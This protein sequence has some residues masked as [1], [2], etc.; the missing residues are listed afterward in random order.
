MEKTKIQVKNDTFAQ[1]IKFC[2]VGVS[3]TLVDWASFYFLTLVITPKNLEPIAKGIA[4]L[5]AM[6]N[7]YFWN[8]KWTFKKEYENQV[9]ESDNSTKAK[10]EIFLKFFL[11]SLGGWLINVGSFWLVRFQFNQGKIVALIAASASA[12][13]FNFVI[14]KLWTYREEA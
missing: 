7:S 14:N 2:V 13:M 8:S 1:F 11:V 5:I 9:N 4:F 3:N 6:I 10:S 12:T